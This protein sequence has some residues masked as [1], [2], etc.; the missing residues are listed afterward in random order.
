MVVAVDS[1]D[2]SVVLSMETLSV[3]GDALLDVSDSP[4]LLDALGLVEAAAGFEVVVATTDGL[5][6]GLD[7]KTVERVD[8]NWIGHNAVVCEL[9]RQWKHRTLLRHSRLICPLR[10]QRKQLPRLRS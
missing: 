2:R 6:G 4:L 1:R 3:D 7:E 8:L 10:P 9:L 5:P